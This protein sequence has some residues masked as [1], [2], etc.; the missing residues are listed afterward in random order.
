M[1]GVDTCAGTCVVPH[2]VYATLPRHLLEQ[3]EEML[4][5]AARHPEL[6]GSR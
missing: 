3:Q 6:D 4:S 2:A 1:T 5:V